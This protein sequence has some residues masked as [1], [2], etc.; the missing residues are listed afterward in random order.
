[1]R[2]V[3]TATH[4]SLHGNVVDSTESYSARL[5]PSKKLKPQSYDRGFLCLIF[6]N[7][8]LSFERPTLDQLSGHA[9]STKLR[10]NVK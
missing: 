4:I 5:V 6:I 9:F 10:I 2:T 8:Y 1:M 3:H 7:L